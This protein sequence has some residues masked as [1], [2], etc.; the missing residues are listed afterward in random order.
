METIV[1]QLIFIGIILFFGE[2]IFSFI[3]GKEWTEAGK[4]AKIFVLFYLVRFIFSSQSTMLTTKRKLGLE[5]RFNLF[6][7][8]TQLLSLFSGYYLF[9][10]YVYT[11]VFMSISGFI[12]FTI[13]GIIIFRLS[14][15]KIETD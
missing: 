8:I 2:D 11:F 12:M 6:F 5:A 14:R 3:F 7:L 10:D 4:L 1:D 13:F 15:L 9:D